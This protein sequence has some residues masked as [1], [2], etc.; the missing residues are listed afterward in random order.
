MPGFDSIIDQ[1]RPI[2]TLASFLTH[3]TIPHA[4]LF[5]GIEG[6]GKRT[7]AIAFAMACNCMGGPRENGTAA[8]GRPPATARACGE[9]PACRKI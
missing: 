1:E 7:A 3:G 2:R 6:V 5:T 9:C 8:A 4:L